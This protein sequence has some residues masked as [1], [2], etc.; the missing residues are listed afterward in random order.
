LHRVRKKSKPRRAHRPAALPPGFIYANG[1]V[2]GTEIAASAESA[3]RV[4]ESRLKE[5]EA[6]AAGEVL[7]RPDDA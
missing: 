1:H 6:V 7:V 5:G 3:G 4:V 2:E